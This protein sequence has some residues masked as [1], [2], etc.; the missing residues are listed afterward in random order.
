MALTPR[1]IA[2]QGVQDGPLE[3]AVQ[4]LLGL[5]VGVGADLSAT[6]YASASLTG[7][8]PEQTGG[9]R[10]RHKNPLLRIELF[11]A[12]EPDPVTAPQRTPEVEEILSR[13]FH[14]GPKPTFVAPKHKQQQT[15]TKTKPL[16]PLGLGRVLNAEKPAQRIDK[17]ISLQASPSLDQSDE[18][19]DELMV[20]AALELMEF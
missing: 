15:A 19:G 16:V 4:G 18:E 10:K 7:A 11:G 5:E 20:L 17:P 6:L 9:G 13:I 1:V 3:T 14:V 8:L 12:R 2:T